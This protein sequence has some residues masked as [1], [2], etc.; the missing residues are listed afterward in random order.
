MLGDV[1]DGRRQRTGQVTGSPDTQVAS[2]HLAL[3]TF[4]FGPKALAL[5]EGFGLWGAG[6]GS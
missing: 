1:K 3:G 6:Y 5:D 2:G 4:G